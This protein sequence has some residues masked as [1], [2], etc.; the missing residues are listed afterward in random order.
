[1]TSE[2]YIIEILVKAENKGMRVSMLSS[3]SSLLKNNASLSR[4]DAFEKAYNSIQ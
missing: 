4:I 1:M 2:D 3:V